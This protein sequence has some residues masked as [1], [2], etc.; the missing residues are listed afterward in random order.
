MHFCCKDYGSNFNHSDVMD[1]K[2]MK[3]GEMSADFH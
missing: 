1:A 3:F 2:A